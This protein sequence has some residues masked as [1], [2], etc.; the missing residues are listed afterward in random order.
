M[1]GKQSRSASTDLTTPKAVAR[2]QKVYD[3]IVAGKC[4][5]AAAELDATHG[6]DSNG[7]RRN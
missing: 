4:K 2:S 1:F 7:K 6:T 5:N 3:R